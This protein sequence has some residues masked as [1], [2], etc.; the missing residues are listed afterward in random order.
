MPVT[1]EHSG[2]MACLG[3]SHPLPLTE[4]TSPDGALC[5]RCQ[6][7]QR[8]RTFPVAFAPVSTEEPA[9][10]LDGEAVCFHHSTKRA[11]VPCDQCGRFLCSLC[12]FTIGQH[13]LCPS[14]I[15]AERSRQT[16]RWV[17]RRLNLDSVA[18]SAATVPMLGIWTT[19]AG[20]PVAIYLGIRALS[21]PPGPVPRGR[22]RAIVAIILGA[23]QV[24][25][26]AALLI[27]IFGTALFRG[28]RLG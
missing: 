20:G 13:H 26:W 16:G 23:I 14:C 6:T 28:G 10:A 25:A 5:P 19:I 17:G 11:V 2:S 9:N 24:L 4:I 21:Q 1:V 27:T 22:S 12:Q 15:A 3:C 18:L 7:R 8:G